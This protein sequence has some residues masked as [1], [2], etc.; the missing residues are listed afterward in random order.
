MIYE[1]LRFTLKNDVT[2]LK[3]IAPY[4]EKFAG[5][6]G[7]TK[8]IL[9]EIT[10]CIDEH[11]TNIITHGYHDDDT[12]WIQITLAREEDR[13][14]VRIE[15][16]GHAFNPTVPPAPSLKV[17]LEEREIGGLG[18]YLAKHYMDD[19]MYERR[20]DSNVVVMTKNLPPPGK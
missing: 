17:P 5:L 1:P 6:Q 3:K 8:K 2:E 4:L 20:G 10:L 11:V 15:D 12:H 19:M 18:I 9:F 16:D 13:L 14:S 7:L